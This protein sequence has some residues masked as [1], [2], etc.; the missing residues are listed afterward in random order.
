MA[1]ILQ[2]LG[3]TSN[4]FT[5]PSAI[6]RKDLQRVRR[7]PYM[8][9]EKTD[10]VRYLLAVVGTSAYLIG[11]N[12]AKIDVF[13]KGGQTAG[14]MLLDGELVGMK[15]DPTSKLFIVYDAL[16]TAT[17]GHVAH[18]HLNER[19]SAMAADFF[20]TAPS[21]SITLPNGR[22]VPVLRKGLV[23]FRDGPTYIQNVVPC[24]PYRSDGL[25]FTPVNEAIRFGTCATLFKWK[26]LESNTV[27]FLISPDGDRHVLSVVDRAQPV[28]VAE[29]RLEHGSMLKLLIDIDLRK[30]KPVICECA[31]DHKSKS[32][33]PRKL[34]TDK[35]QPNSVMTFRATIR[36]LEEDIRLDD[37]FC[38]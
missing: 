2:A 28:A 10:G 30:R 15:K 4:C 35:V 18:L 14:D 1:A 7:E 8:V 5:F 25:I 38:H 20:D 19:L 24:L 29:T 36:N 27:D 26:L 17:R 12:M 32:W 11:R 33:Q 37:I 3:V 13:L 34:R 31:W 6:E 22:T 23:P 16:R 21:W 9:A